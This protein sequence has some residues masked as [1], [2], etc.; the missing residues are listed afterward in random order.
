MSTLWRAT[1]LIQRAARIELMRTKR[2]HVVRQR[3]EAWEPYRSD[4]ADPARNVRLASRLD[5]VLKT[6][7]FASFGM[8]LGVTWQDV[9]EQASWKTCWT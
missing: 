1:I 7:A 3:A 9:K 2:S 5:A 4:L 8:T 6:A